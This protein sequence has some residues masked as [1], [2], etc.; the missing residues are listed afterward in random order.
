MLGRWDIA[1][2]IFAAVVLF[3]AG[4]AAGGLIVRLW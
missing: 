2:I 1:A 3:L 4:A